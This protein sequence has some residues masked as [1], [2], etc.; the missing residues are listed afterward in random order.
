ME[1]LYWCIV[2]WLILNDFKL[3]KSQNKKIKAAKSVYFQSSTFELTDEKELYA[4]YKLEFRLIPQVHSHNY[5]LTIKTL[6]H[7]TPTK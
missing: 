7:S 1:K 3:S 6:Y 5:Y 4:D 2:V